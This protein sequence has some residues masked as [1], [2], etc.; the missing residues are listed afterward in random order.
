MNESVN[1]I[2]VIILSFI[3]KL[4]CDKI[5]LTDSFIVK[6]A[7]ILKLEG[8][9]HYNTC[10]S[11]GWRLQNDIPASSNSRTHQYYQTCSLIIGVVL[12]FGDEYG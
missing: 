10:S 8:G 7:G 4:A 2:I 5:L 9:G 1:R 3:V 6:L 12:E 11:T